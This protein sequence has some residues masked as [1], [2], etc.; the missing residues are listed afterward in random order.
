MARKK[1]KFDY[2][3]AFERQAKI[4]C[5]EAELL[6][7][8][9]A[10]F[11][12][13]ENLGEM[14]QAAHRIEQRGDDVNHEILRSVAVDF[15]TPIDREDVI[16]MAHRLDAVTDNIESVIQCLYMYDAHRIHDSA[17]EMADLILKSTQALARAAEGFRDFKNTAKLRELLEEVNTHEE[18]ADYVYLQ[19]TRK[20]YTEER[21]EV[22][23]VAVWSRIF[24]SMEKACDACEHVADTMSNIMLKNM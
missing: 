21:E 4:A 7:E 23:R 9:I 12:N 2:F 18:E 14:L 10:K 22:M 3:D 17:V 20:L 16:D 15:I 19:V 24:D 5:E 1:V 11:D 13:H 8:I 6:V